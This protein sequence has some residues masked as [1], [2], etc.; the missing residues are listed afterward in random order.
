MLILLLCNSFC[1][2]GEASLVPWDIPK[3]Q[4]E[5]YIY[6]KHVMLGP[7]QLDVMNFDGIFF[8]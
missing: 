3:Q 8:I 7:L 6:N 4:M 2:Q 5:Q 1:L